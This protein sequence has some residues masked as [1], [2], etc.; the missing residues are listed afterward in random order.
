VQ[1]AKEV[2]DEFRT[3][4]REIWR[5]DRAWAYAYLRGARNSLQAVAREKRREQAPSPR[6]QSL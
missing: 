4:F 1:V 2:L 6:G 5:L 3:A